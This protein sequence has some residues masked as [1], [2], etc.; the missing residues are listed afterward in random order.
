MSSNSL[1]TR[2]ASAYLAALARHDD[3]AASELVKRTGA[4]LAT[5]VRDARLLDT[6]SVGESHRYPLL[7]ATAIDNTSVEVALTAPSDND[8]IL[9]LLRFLRTDRLDRAER[10]GTRWGSLRGI[11][12]EALAQIFSVDFADMGDAALDWLQKNLP[13]LGNSERE[14]L[15][16]LG[17]ASKLDIRRLRILN[18]LGLKLGAHKKCMETVLEKCCLWLAQTNAW[19]EDCITSIEELLEIGAAPAADADMYPLELISAIRLNSAIVL[20]RLHAAGAK[21]LDIDGG[22]P[23]SRALSN[24]RFVDRMLES[25]YASA[26]EWLLSHGHPIEMEKRNLLYEGA[27]S[28]CPPLFELVLSRAPDAMGTISTMKKRRFDESLSSTIWQ[29]RM[30]RFR[31]QQRQQNAQSAESQITT[32]KSMNRGTA[33]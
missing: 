12:I 4:D 14:Y 3:V 28:L 9:C 2:D 30:H 5:R 24:T 7:L 29:Q 27:T 21:F 18:A 8:A 13:P 23:L 1:S 22:F 26:A 15:I 32:R 6:I 20:E 25:G 33:L 31:E 11:H 16:A 10:I 19:E 17:A